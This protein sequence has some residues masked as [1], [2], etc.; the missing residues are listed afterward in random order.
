MNRQNYSVGKKI[1]FVILGF[2]AMPIADFIQAAVSFPA[3]AGI[4]A[5][6]ALDQPGS[7]Q[8]AIEGFIKA[9]ING[10]FGDVVSIVYSIVA[11]GVF[12]VWF[13]IIFRKDH[14]PLVRHRHL[15]IQVILGL[16]L[17]MISLQFL[18]DIVVNIT[19]AVMP[20]ALNQYEELME[21]AGFDEPST[22]GYIYGILIGPIAEELIFRGVTLHYFKRS[23]P[24]V[25]ANI[26]QAVLFG[27][28]HMNVIQGVYAFVIGLFLGGIFETGQSLIFSIMAHIIF[29]LFGFT[30]ILTFG[31]DTR[32]Y[33]YM[34][35]PVMVLFMVLG[36]M[37]YFGRLKRLNES[38]S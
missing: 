11:I 5:E 28:Y 2:L 4:F 36:S 27:I 21:M 38:P 1:L 6:A 31:S 29:N 24:F 34:W 30:E 15:S 20:G 23:M 18:C 22:A 35:M 8:G 32:L 12:G 14:G 26:F 37:L 17:L 16:F 33:Y 3:A 19:E 13:F 25:L 9:F 10:R 7:L